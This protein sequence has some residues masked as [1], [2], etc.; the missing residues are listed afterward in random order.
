MLTADEQ[1][2]SSAEP[3]N[4]PFRTLSGE[5]EFNRPARLWRTHG[6]RSAASLNKPETPS[7]T[8]SG[9]R[10]QTSGRSEIDQIH[11]VAGAAA[12]WENFKRLFDTIKYAQT[13]DGER[14]SSRDKYHAWTELYPITSVE[15]EPYPIVQLEIDADKKAMK[16]LIK[17]TFDDDDDKIYYIRKRYSDFKEFRTQLSSIMNDRDLNSHTSNIK[18]LVPDPYKKFYEGFPSANQGFPEGK[19]HHTP[20]NMNERM[21]KLNKWIKSMHDLFMECK[22]SIPNNILENIREFFVGDGQ[23]LSLDDSLP[24]S[25]SDRA[26]LWRSENPWRPPSSRSKGG[27]YRRRKKAVTK[28]RSRKTKRR[29]RKKAV[30]KRKKVSKSRKSKRRLKTK[31]R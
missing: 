5:A 24:R 7:F 6:R 13:I 12:H 22:K 23:P 4:Y 8:V 1:Q 10:E 25:D 2:V 30:T 15:I 16:Y 21:K 20:Q 3:S 14:A 31:R 26:A 9:S 28:R 18:T 27:G 19:L 29:S 11:D 17:F